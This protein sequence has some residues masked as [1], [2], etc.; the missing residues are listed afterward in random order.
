MSETRLRTAGRTLAVVLTPE[1]D[2]VAARVDDVARRV[3]ALRTT[4]AATVADATI[5]DVDLVLDGRT[6]HAVVARTRD[7]I[8]VALDG[9]TVVFERLD[10]A[11]AGAGAGAGSG[12]V[13]APMPG[14]VV[15]VLVGV[16]DVVSAGQAL[17]V[18]EA[19]KMETTLVAEIDGTVT[20]VG[21]EAGAMVDAG[22]VLVAISPPDA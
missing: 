8:L 10:E 12:T 2:A 11:T 20:S 18:V 7:R 21:A 13:V 5:E 19:M 6:V 17:V 1:G 15:T 4:R 16:G 9:D 22:A 3:D 14:K